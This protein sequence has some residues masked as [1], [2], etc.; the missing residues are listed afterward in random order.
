[1]RTLYIE[2]ATPA[3]A[4]LL[5]DEASGS[6]IGHVSEEVGRGH[7]ERLVPM[8]ATLEG[9]GRAGRIVV[10]AGPG[11]FTGIRVGIAAARGL[12]LAWGSEVV[13]MSSLA[14][15]AAGARR[16]HGLA[17]ELAVVLEG[18]HGEVF[19]QVFAAPDDVL[20]PVGPVMSLAPGD[21]IAMIGDRSAFGAGLHRLPAL[22][23]RQRLGTGLPDVTA[24]PL[25]PAALRSL[26]P[27][28]RYGRAPD[29]K[30]PAS[31]G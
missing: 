10:D 20:A 5:V 3:C 6:V 8:I 19:M 17:T 28:P 18:G 24:A 12:G 26:P 30:L 23:D 25:L 15:L 9:G 16:D 14:L 29:A 11:S 13:A 22:P 31:R 1:M 4:A 21:A 27:S 2:T 7:A